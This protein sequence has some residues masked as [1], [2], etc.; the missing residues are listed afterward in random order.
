MSTQQVH[1]D[2][3]AGSL[4]PDLTLGGRELAIIVAVWAFLA[5]VVLAGRLLDPRVPGLTA[6]I[7]AA[8]VRTTLIEYTLWMLLTPPLL[9]FAGRLTAEER[10]R[11]FAVLS[12]VVVGLA[13]A[14][15]VDWLIAQV[16]DSV[17]P[18]PR[19]RRGG[20]PFDRPRPFRSRAFGDLGFVDDLMVYLAVLS[21]GIARATLL[22]D[23]ERR[24]Q[25]ARLQAQAA[26]LK[27][28]L[29]EA[30]LD[31]L[32][33]QLDPHFL[34]N[35]LNAVSALVERD[36]RGV[37]RMIARLSELLRHTLEGSADEIALGRE[38]ELLDRYL[39]IMR[40]RF[41]DRLRVAIDVPGELREALVPNLLLQPLVE[42]AIKHAVAP[43]EEG[44]HVTV[45]ARRDGSALVLEVLDDGPGPGASDI[46]VGSGVG[47]SNSRAR[48]AALYGTAQHLHLRQR[49]DAPGA[50]VEVSLPLRSS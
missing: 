15:A 39:D 21:A 3:D 44:G 33:A 50:V 42:N 26:E 24:A 48:L 20:G 14:L 32:R 9:W 31:V 25:T 17:F 5:L 13:L 43:R 16:R 40:V 4:R 19:R 45:R 36:P 12:A 10:N 22:L 41:G 49:G 30:R 47:L 35:T 8:V 7:N 2:D 46:P 29:A 23:R 6:E 38:L 28:Q 34:F 11:L 37:R 1:H 18:A 27:A